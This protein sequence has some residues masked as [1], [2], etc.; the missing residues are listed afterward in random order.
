MGAH[1]HPR[2]QTQDQEVSTTAQARRQ[3]PGHT[4]NV[5]NKHPQAK[6]QTRCTTRTQSRPASTTIHRAEREGFSTSAVAKA[7]LVE[8]QLSLAEGARRP[9]RPAANTEDPHIHLARMART[10]QDTRAAT[11]LQA[12]LAAELC[13]WSGAL[14]RSKGASQHP[15]P[16][17]PR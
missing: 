17:E 2:P 11:P 16:A 14:C 3:G 8:G 15:E 9:A 10:T 6:S 13:W 7:T 5:T 12:T 1:Q 4:K